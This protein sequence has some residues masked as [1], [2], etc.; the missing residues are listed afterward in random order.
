MV[1]C[2]RQTSDNLVLCRFRLFALRPTDVKA[3]L[4]SWPSPTIMASARINVSETARNLGAIVDSQLTLSAQVSAFCQWL[5]PATAA[6]TAHQ[7]SV[8]CRR[9]SAGPGVHFMSLG[10]L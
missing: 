2:G 8:I 5:L 3:K 6:P 10:L 9:Q 4:I 7:I 1:V